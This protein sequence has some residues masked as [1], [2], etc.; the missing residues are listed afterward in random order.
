MKVAKL[1]SITLIARVIVDKNASEVDILNEAKETFINKIR[2]E[3][4]ENLDKIEYDYEC[5]FGTVFTDRQIN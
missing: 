2:N 3:S 1:V 5:P 4:I